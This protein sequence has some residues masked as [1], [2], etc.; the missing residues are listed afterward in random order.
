MACDTDPAA[1]KTR[2]D[3]AH[4]LQDDCRRND[5]HRRNDI[6]RLVVRRSRYGRFAGGPDPLAD[7]VDVAA[8][9][10][11]LGR[12]IM[13]GEPLRDALRHL[14]R[15]GPG[16]RPG[17][18]DLARSIRQRLAQVSRAGRLDGL[19]QDLR[20]L[21]DQAMQ[22][23]RQALFADPSDDA[24]FQEAVL[25][26]V[27]AEVGRA[28]RALRDYQ[29]TS[30]QARQLFDQVNER[31]RRDVI[32][33]QFRSISQAMHPLA[34]PAQQER[35]RNML[36]DLNQ[37]LDRHRAGTATD[38]DYQTFIDAHRDFFPDA[39]S[40]LDEFIDELARQSAAMGRMLASMSPEQR[41]ELA[42]AMQQAW[43]D[44][45]LDDQMAQ[46]QQHLHG[47]RP[48]FDWNGQQSVT[49]SDRLGLPD[50]TAALAE[51]ADL[52]ALA[53]QVNEA[54]DT[55]DL[56]AIDEAAVQ[57]A[58]GRNSRDDLAGLQ[59][60]QRTL[61]DAGY[62][63]DDHTQLTPKALRRIGQSALR[64]VFESLDGTERGAHGVHR[65]GPAGEPTGAHLAWS[66]GDEQAIDVVRTVQNAA[67][68]RAAT[69]ASGPPLSPDDFEVRQ[70]ET[71]TRAA[72]ALLIDR[73]F[74][75]AIND[76]WAAAKTLA[77]ALQA[78]TS[79]A[80]PL[81]AVQVITFANLAEVVH[82]VDL[83]NLEVSYVQGT[84]LQ[85]G[86]MLASRFLER[87]PGAQ[88]IVMVVTDGEPTAH[89]LP[90]GDWWF[91]W[92]PSP[93]TIAATV[94]QVDRLTRRQVPI[95]W[96][97]IGD[98]PRLAAFLDAM[99]ARNRGRVLA[100]SPDRLGDYVIRDYVR[101]RARSARPA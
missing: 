72:V 66:F 75:M 20:D 31:L 43:T 85:H 82:P 45:G 92:P 97:R 70:T 87:H 65:G 98:E 53:T 71:V 34:D 58:L 28:V 1:R 88:P 73:S 22:A 100:P 67:R 63:S 76:T 27:P 64:A 78:L 10:D 80:F 9:V 59:Q 6:H 90:E 54:I 17:L 94:A 48:E 49:G 11:D 23:E 26:N 15:G 41:A 2:L 37:L 56:D 60:M 3:A 38:D 51:L 47:L 99:A 16:D 83:P 29:W 101:S 24:R 19:L 7:P 36:A 40:T 96:F 18:D 89:L 35:L 93:E 46:L 52:E 30:P 55:G 91:D 68:R 21:L 32:D 4:Q 77:L 44:L 12:R 81:D 33:Q 42:E 13:S 8:A 69:G 61:V 79:M 95:S 14:R 25:D 50:A 5:V 84:N 86:L 39:P 74:S 57:R 62:L